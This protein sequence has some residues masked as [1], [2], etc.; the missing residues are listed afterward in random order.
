MPL[1]LSFE[2]APLLCTGIA[3]NGTIEIGGPEQL[4]FDDFIRKVLSARHDP[5]EV[6]ADPHP[7]C[8]GAEPSERA[9][10][11]GDGAQLDETRFADWLK[12]S[13]AAAAKG[14]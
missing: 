4:R 1:V 2:A 13:A 12:K 5:R 3:T 14:A 11:P 9:L 10:I 6:I 8:V 7:R